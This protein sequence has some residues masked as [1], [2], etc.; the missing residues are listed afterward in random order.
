M[1]FI[2]LLTILIEIKPAHSQVYFSVGYNVGRFT[3]GLPNLKNEVYHFN[4]V[5]FK[6]WDNNFKFVNLPH[7]LSFE[8]GLRG[9]KF[10]YF[11]QWSNKHIIMHGNGPNP[12]NISE[13]MNY[14]FKVRLNQFSFCNFGYMVTPKFGIGINAIDLGLFKFL[15]KTNV[16]QNNSTEEVN[17]WNDYY[18]VNTGL[19]SSYS[20]SCSGLF[21][22]YDVAKFLHLRL[23][24]DVDLFGV[25]LGFSPNHRYRANNLTLNVSIRFNKN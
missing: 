14:D 13:E 23:A 12:K 4:T 18:A 1:A 20:T 17:K 11:V 25:N 21:I 3:S 15:Y 7:G 9:D 22:D 24:Y 2:M 8:V 10:Y 19:L 16:A 6:N 5:D